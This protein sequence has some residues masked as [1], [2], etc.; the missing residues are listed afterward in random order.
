MRSA[1]PRWIFPASPS[2]QVPSASLARPFLPARRLVRPGGLAMGLS[3]DLCRVRPAG[4]TSR[5]SAHR[6]K[7]FRSSQSGEISLRGAH[8][9]CALWWGAGP[10]DAREGGIYTRM[11]WAGWGILT[12]TAFV[13]TA[14]ALLLTCFRPLPPSLLQLLFVSPL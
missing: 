6:A 14:P 2:H 12:R 8:I 10:A 11:G 9:Q 3:G 7:L 4:E 5:Q 13:R 1:P